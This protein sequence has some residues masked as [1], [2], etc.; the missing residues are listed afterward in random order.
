M[1]HLVV[2]NLVVHNLVLSTAALGREWVSLLYSL[3]FQF[4]IIVLHIVR[5]VFMKSVYP[6]YDSRSS[7]LLVGKRYH[8]MPRI[9]VF[10]YLSL[11]KKDSDS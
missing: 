5:S 9:A 1:R 2:H 6:Q 10:G 3:V 7:T 4:S 11:C 8:G